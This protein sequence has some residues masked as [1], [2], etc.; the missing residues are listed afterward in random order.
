MQIKDW[1]EFQWKTPYSCIA[2]RSI[3]GD[4]LVEVAIYRD[5]TY[6]YEIMWAS[7]A[8]SLH[9]SYPESYIA[10]KGFDCYTPSAKKPTL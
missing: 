2:G 10:W 3:P 6:K 5:N 7:I 4:F 9:K 1:V 8:T